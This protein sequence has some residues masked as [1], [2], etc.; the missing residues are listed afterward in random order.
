MAVIWGRCVAETKIIRGRLKIS[1]DL[2]EYWSNEWCLWIKHASCYPQSD[3]GDHCM[4]MRS[5]GCISQ[6]QIRLSQYILCINEHAVCVSSARR[7][8]PSDFFRW[9]VRKPRKICSSAHNQLWPYVLPT[10]PIEKSSLYPPEVHSINL[11]KRIQ[12]IKKKKTDT[13]L[14]TESRWPHRLSACP[15]KE[16]EEQGQ[17][18]EKGFIWEWGWVT[19]EGRS[20][21]TDVKTNNYEQVI[22][23]FPSISSPDDQTSPPTWRLCPKL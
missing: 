12:R 11:V 2:C 21:R 6:Q 23:K 17:D 4:C 3:R 1:A 9:P 8:S 13:R 16:N 5:T 20:K 7:L 19:V 22:N 14:R 15:C 10:I 18:R